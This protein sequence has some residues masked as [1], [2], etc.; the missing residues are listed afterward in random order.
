MKRLATLETNK[1]HNASA[2]S[3]GSVVHLRISP[4]PIKV[5]DEK[6]VV[7]VTDLDVGDPVAELCEKAWFG[8]HAGRVER[9]S[10]ID[11]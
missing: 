8:I 5:R 1:L 10:R 9:V 6:V 3:R 2:R 11:M 7:R 4:K